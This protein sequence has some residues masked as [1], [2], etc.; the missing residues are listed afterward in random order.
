MPRALTALLVVFAATTALAQAPLD[1]NAA[2]AT[3]N[4]EPIRAAEYYRRLEW[5]TPNPQSA[6]GNLPV[7]FQVLRQM[8][9]ERMIMQLAKSKDVAP[10][11]PEIEARVAEF[12]Q[13]N[14]N[15]KTQLAE[16]GRGDADVR[17]EA[18][19][20]EAQ[21]KLV[22]AGVTITDL[23]V[24]KRYKDLPS[25]FEEPQRYKLSVIAVGGDDAIAKVDTA[26][27]AGRPFADV[28][29][30]NSLDVRSRNAGG[31]YGDVPDTSLP[32]L[33]RPAIAA[34][35][36]GG[37]SAWVKTEQ[38]ARLKFLVEKITPAKKLPL[39]AALKA[40]IRRT[41]MLERGNQK[42]KVAQ[43]LDAATLA[44]TVTFA[45]PRFQQLYDQIVGQI[46]AQ[47]AAK[48]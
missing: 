5:F 18:A 40:K 32:E 48:G 42:N 25:Q 34:T 43:D 27:K 7:G 6:L 19:N 33:I 35:P 46:K 2:V 16:A 12:Y 13:K 29:K 28:A 4:G 15:L 17:T 9:S 22:T 24:E 3:V 39:D 41:M 20:E 45:Q 47:K 37:T 26:L 11:A 36:V 10:T 8:V 31:A 23:E 21:F 1:G 38:G 30:E 14:P 44:A